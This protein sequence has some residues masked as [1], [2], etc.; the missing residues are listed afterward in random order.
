MRNS[1]YGPE[2]RFGPSVLTS[3][4]GGVAEGSSL[5]PCRHLAGPVAGLLHR[6]L[7]REATGIG[8]THL[9]CRTVELARERYDVVCWQP[10][11]AVHQHRAPLWRRSP[12]GLQGPFFLLLHLARAHVVHLDHQHGRRSETCL[13]TGI[14]PAFKP[15]GF[16][17]GKRRVRRERFERRGFLREFWTVR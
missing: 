11:L 16:K 4:I 15:D 14:S 7:D 8:V 17:A 2:R 6:R 1:G 12:Q 9:Q 10:R 13:I 5:L 3:A